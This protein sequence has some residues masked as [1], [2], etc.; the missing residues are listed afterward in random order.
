MKERLRTAS[1]GDLI[2]AA[3]DRASRLSS[4]PRQ[5]SRKALMAIRV[6]LRET[7]ESLERRWVEAESRATAALDTRGV[8]TSTAQPR[9]AKRA[10]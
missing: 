2:A 3:F 8:I 4:N 6:V 5:I 1:L 10:R 7:Q 9:A